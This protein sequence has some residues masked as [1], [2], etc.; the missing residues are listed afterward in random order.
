[1]V[2]LPSLVAAGV[3]LAV[4][5]AVFSA[6]V[7]LTHR[8]VFAAAPWTVAASTL[9]VAR[10]AGLH[11]GLAVPTVVVVAA[12]AGMALGIWVLFSHMAALRGL[13]YSERYLVASGVGAAVM[14]VAGLFG[15]IEGI[16]PARAVWVAFAPVLAAVLAALGYFLLGLVYTEALVAFR[17]AGL[18]V[19][20]TVVLDGAASAAAAALG[21]V[22]SGVVTAAI[23][24]VLGVDL[25]PWL[26]LPLQALLGVAVV[27]CCGGLARLYGPAGY[28]FALGLSTL[29]LGS[30]TVVLLSA[31]LLG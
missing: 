30:G 13:E 22:E 17:L 24:L 6:P 14:V 7:P 25:S 15:T 1:M 31:T 4:V 12:V 9:V 23:G 28:G 10:R 11:D 3:V 18:Y 20:W 21:S 27:G 26:A 19:V 5:A 8:T 16:E 29:S 2:G